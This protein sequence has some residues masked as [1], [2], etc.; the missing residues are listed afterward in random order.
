MN[1]ITCKPCGKYVIFFEFLALWIN[2]GLKPP[3]QQIKFEIRPITSVP[4]PKV[5]KK[6]NFILKHF[7][8]YIQFCSKSA[9][10]IILPNSF[11]QSIK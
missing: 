11:V 3:K 7:G 4:F 5:N 9:L 1:D 10:N 2:D 6:L 8:L